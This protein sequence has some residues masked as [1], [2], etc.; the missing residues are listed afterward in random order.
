VRGVSTRGGA[1]GLGVATSLDMAPLGDPRWTPLWDVVSASRLPVHFPPVGGQRPD[2]DKLPPSL[3]RV[4]HAVHIT[5]FQIHMATILM[6]MIFGGVLERYPTLRVVIGE[7]G[8][9]WIP[10]ILERMDAEWED[11]FRDLALSLR[12]SE[13]WRRQ[14]K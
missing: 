3:G 11:Q 6:S 5:G 13:Y 1:R 4:A 14:C 9:G 12:P 8:I 7:S 10:Y 2:F